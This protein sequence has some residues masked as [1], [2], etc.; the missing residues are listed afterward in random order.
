MKQTKLQTKLLI[1]VLLPLLLQVLFAL[2]F[3]IQ[4]ERFEQIA[5]NVAKSRELIGRSNW[6]NYTMVSAVTAWMAYRSNGQSIYKTLSRHFNFVTRENLND[7]AV[8]CQDSK[9]T[10]VPFQKLRKST[11]AVLN[12]TSEAPD[13]KTWLERE[14]LSKLVWG[15]IP[16][17]RSRLLEAVNSSVSLRAQELPDYR[18]ALKL[19][20]WAAILVNLLL[21]IVASIILVKDIGRRIGRLAENSARLAR[22]ESLLPSVSGNDELFLLDQQFRSMADELGASLRKERAVAY[23]SAEMICTVDSDLFLTQ[24]NPAGAKLFSMRSEE[25]IGQNLAKLLPETSI[26]KFKE[27]M[28]E[29]SESSNQSSWETKITNSCG[30]EL[31]LLWSVSW[32]RDDSRFYCV[33]HDET[34]KN[35]AQ[36]LKAQVLHMIS[37]D[38]RTPLMTVTGSLEFIDLRVGNKLEV[39]DQKILARGLVACGNLLKMATDLL[40]MEKIAS[41]NLSLDVKPFKIDKIVSTA[42]DT[43]SVP[44]EQKNISLQYVDCNQVVSGDPDRICQVLVNLIGNAIKFS[45]PGSAITVT[46]RAFADNLE[47]R[48]KDN[49]PGIQQDKLK[50]IF[51]RFKQV[52]HADSRNQKGVGLGLAISKGIVEQ[53]GGKIWCESEAGAGATFAFTIARA[54]PDE[55]AQADL[56]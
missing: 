13:I 42:F 34:A 51:D 14:A 4:F 11:E 12:S 37:H 54:M 53:H 43:T 15:E 22:E 1:L 56:G 28:G 25:L 18:N 39:Q 20:L 3:Y 31:D 8:I 41:G 10:A 16:G 17:Y 50:V 29:G 30:Q 27:L 24:V 35:E 5:A 52:N 7:I 48:V 47:V 6:L 19:S 2:S 46:V 38:I 36:N 26:G 49:G 45:P 23:N 9:E 40:E 44:A 55:C 21:S 33:V 32:A